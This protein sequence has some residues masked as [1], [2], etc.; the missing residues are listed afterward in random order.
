MAIKVALLGFGT[1]ATG[2][3]KL[4]A[5]NG[6]AIKT[7]LG[8]DI[9]ISKVLVRNQEKQEQ[10]TKGEYPYKFVTEIDEIIHDD[11][12]DVVI[13][14][15]GRLEPAKTYI[16]QAIK[17]G[18]H[19]ITANKDLIALHGQELIALAQE[20]GVAFY[21][22][23]AVAGGIPIL[24][25]LSQSL[26]VDKISRLLGILNGTT[27][28]MLTQMVEQGW[29]YEQALTEAQRLGYAESDPTN[30]VEGIDAAYKASILAQ[31]AFGQVLDFAQVS[32]QGI[33]SISD[34]DVTLAQELGYVIK[35][36]G[37]VQELA[38]GLTVG[39]A[40]TLVP[41]THPLAGVNGAMNAVLVE[42]FGLGQS[43]YYGAGAGQLPTATSVMADLLHIAQ[44]I[45]QNQPVVPFTPQAQRADL[46]KAE[47]VSH[48]YYLLVKK[49]QAA[50]LAQLPVAV[51]QSV[52]TEQEQAVIT[53]PI[54][55]AALADF[56]AKHQ[57]S[58]INAFK[59]LGE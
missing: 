52:E 53:E 58:I 24:R 37:D 41:V 23:A 54:S 14:L 9:I 51:S 21:Y 39:V 10:L 28:F 16:E 50:C 47:D 7:L 3:P 8:D 32:H 57:A 48:P 35:L 45:K 12:L 13:E 46:A 17:A 2:L 4:L 42:S 40:P 22:E 44:G 43:M 19:V 18:K 31:F 30:D 20:Q 56:L 34:T 15:M 49:E 26:A 5:E 59:V 6:Q 38:S 33:A 29:T 36:I 11:S 27:N 25:T 55:Q 1:V